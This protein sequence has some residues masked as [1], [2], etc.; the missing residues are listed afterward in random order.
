MYIS[1]N[2]LIKVTKNKIKMHQ[3]YKVLLLHG[4]NFMLQL[5][6]NYLHRRKQ[7]QRL[8]EWIFIP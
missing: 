5:M 7:V 4:D 2:G 3:L 8:F 6:C 1:N